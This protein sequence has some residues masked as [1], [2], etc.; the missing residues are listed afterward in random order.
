M[1]KRQQETEKEKQRDRTETRAT[2][3]I[4]RCCLPP[5]CDREKKREPEAKMLKIYLALLQS[6]FAKIQIVKMSLSKPRDLLKRR[7]E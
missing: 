2:A 5:P 3:Q 4:S 6:G 7:V 1:G